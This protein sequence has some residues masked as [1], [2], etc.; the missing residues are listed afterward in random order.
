MR[1]AAIAF[2]ALVAACGA[3]GGGV[4]GPSIDVDGSVSNDGVDAAA[5]SPSDGA[6]PAQ[7]A[8]DSSSANGADPAVWMRQTIYL[9]MTDRFFNGDPSNDQ[10][11]QPNCTGA[12]SQ[13]LFH[14]GD[15]AGVRQKIGYLQDLGA[16]A[17]WVTPLYAQTPVRNGACGYHGYWADFVDPD[18]GAMEPKLGTI[19][20]ATGLVSDLHAQGMKLVLDMVVNH[21]GRNARIA[22]QHPDW[23][24]DPTTCAQLG[25]AKIYCPLNGLPDFAQ[26]NATVAAYLS[27]LSSGWV[28]RVMPDGIRMDT[29]QHV[30]ASYFASSWFPAVR[31]VRGDLFT[32]A[33]I[34]DEGP[35]TDYMPELNAGFDSAFDFPLRRA[36]VDAFAKSGSLDE[37]AQKTADAIATWG[38]ARALMKTNMLDNHDVP[39]FLTEAGAGVAPAE[40]E[41]RYAI[42]LATMFAL[43][44]I[45]QIY[46]GD[47]LGS[48][49]T[50]NRTDMPSWAWDAAGRAGAHTGFVPDVQATWS[51]VQTL[52]KLRRDNDALYKGSYAE[53]WRPNGGAQNVLA[54][55]RSAAPSRLLV[56]V[57]DA[58]ADEGTVALPWSASHNVAPADKSAW[59]DGTVLE[60]LLKIGAPATLTVA[61]G[62]INVAVSGKFVGIYRAR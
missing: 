61:G 23:F 35:Y 41:T 28:K 25:D 31:G 34:F 29:A 18:D 33:E 11:G 21:S 47:E 4:H 10:A 1:A 3:A 27:A 7:D 22:T 26:E 17:V 53:L 24:H 15:L 30:P 54:F 39:R 16:T 6:S 55:L 37:V 46:A 12:T 44:G 32:V 50:Y 42:A 62:K 2:M 14:G 51:L 43:P 56:V 40:L 57:H 19:A 9:V 45:P 36:F 49:D 58:S 52:A 5:D 8:G 59:P 20:D 48:L 38:V 60:D 13:N